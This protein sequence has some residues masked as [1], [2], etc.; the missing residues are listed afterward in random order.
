MEEWKSHSD[1]KIFR[2]FHEFFVNSFYVLFRWYY[3]S[4]L[5][6]MLDTVFF[7]IRKKNSQLTFL[8]VYHHS[9]MFCLWWIGVKY[10]A[11]G[12]SFLGAMCNCY[13]HVLMY[14]YY[15][16]A[17]CGP[18]V[19]KYLWWKKYLT[20][21]QMAQF[22]FA[23]MMG[24]NALRVGCNFPMWMQYSCNMYMFSFLILFSKF[25]Y[26]EYYSSRALKSTTTKKQVAS[27]W[28]CHSCLL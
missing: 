18:S 7:V 5:L 3:A 22:L 26:R 6:E 4:K 19:R 17:A 13:V 20:I 27:D 10:V 15:F 23:L 12:S 28:I 8:H 16:L 25:F 2:Y 14:T 9:T 21:I 1:Q 24:V 11:G